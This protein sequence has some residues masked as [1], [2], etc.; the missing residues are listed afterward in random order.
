MWFR[1]SCYFIAEILQIVRSEHITAEI[2]VDP[3]AETSKKQIVDSM[4][5]PVPPKK[6]TMKSREE[7]D[8]M[9]EKSFTILTPSAAA[10]AS[11]DDCECRSSRSFISKEWRSYLPRTRYKVLHEISYSLPTRGIL[12][13]RIQSPPRPPAS[14]VSFPTTPSSVAGSEDVTLSDLMCI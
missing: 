7:W 3:G 5:V 12:T 4:P 11:A 13:F 6:K 2:R 9:L 8:E 1:N 14:Q 10:A